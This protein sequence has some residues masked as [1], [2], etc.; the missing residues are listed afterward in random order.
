M[1]YTKFHYLSNAVS[2]HADA[3]HCADIVDS[4]SP[5]HLNGNFLAPAVKFPVERPPCFGIPKPYALV[6]IAFELGGL[7][8][9]ALA[10]EVGRCC[11]GQDA[12]FEELSCHKAG[13]PRLAK[14]D[15]KVKS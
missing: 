15:R 13:R 8:R 5:S 2:G 7:F 9:A 4:E 14:S 6:S 12:R 11:D 3:M 10:L 1:F